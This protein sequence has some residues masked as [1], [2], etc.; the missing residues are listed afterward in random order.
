RRVN[1]LRRKNKIQVV[2]GVLILLAVSAIS[3]VT[4]VKQ[5]LSIPNQLV[6]F[7]N[8]AP[9]EVLAL[10]DKVKTD[11]GKDN[12]HAL[13]D[14]TFQAKKAGDRPLLDQA[15]GFPTKETNLDSLKDV[16]VVPGGQSIGVDM[17]TM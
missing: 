13:D 15:A 14:T 12:V 7:V 11:T 5:Y 6:S 2:I 17:H 9:N 3:F 4:P 1:G 8:Q 16:K 10:A